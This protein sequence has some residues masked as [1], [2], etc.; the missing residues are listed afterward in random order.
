MMETSKQWDFGSALVLADSFVW[1]SGSGFVNVCVYEPKLTVSGDSS[2][3]AV[4]PRKTNGS[5]I[6]D[7]ENLMPSSVMVTSLHPE[8]ILW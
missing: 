7:Y 4:W 3:H 6:N 5:A 8:T 2:N 1:E